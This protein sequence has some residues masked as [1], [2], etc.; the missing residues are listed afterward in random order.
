MPGFA[1]SPP[2]TGLR[3][4]D[5]VDLIGDVNGDGIDDLLLGSTRYEAGQQGNGA[6]FLVYGRSDG[7]GAELPLATLNGADGSVLTGA[8]RDGAGWEVAGLGDVNGDGHDDFAV[9]GLLGKTWV[10][11]GGTAPFAATASLNSL[12]LR[13]GFLAQGFLGVVSAAGDVNGDGLDDILLGSTNASPDYLT[14][15]ASVIFGRSQ[16]W[17]GTL[18]LSD[19]DGTLGFTITG[20]E[21]FQYFGSSVSSA[22]DVN[23]DGFADIIIGGNGTGGL[24]TGA[25][26]VVFGKAGGFATSSTT[27]ALDGLNGFRLASG[28]LN[29]AEVS[30]AGDVNGDGFGDLLVAVLDDA[31]YLVFGR[32]GGW[33]AEVDLRA[34]D[35][36]DGVRFTGFDSRSWGTEPVRAAGDVNGDGFAD[37]LLSRLDQVVGDGTGSGFVVLGHGGAWDASLDLS[38]LNGGNGFELLGPPGELTGLAVGSAGDLNDDGRPDIVLTSP[39]LA[40]GSG[41]A[42]VWLNPGTQGVFYRGTSLADELEGTAQGD[43]LSG[44]GRDDALDGRGGDDLL[45]G[46]LGNDTLRGGAGNDTL[47]AGGGFDV[48]DGGEGRD[49]ASFAAYAAAVS[50]DLRAP[51]GLINL[52]SQGLVSLLGIENLVGTGFND[53]LTGQAG[54]NRL[55]GGGGNDGLLGDGGDDVLFGGAGDDVISGG[56]GADDMAGGAGND[57]YFVDDQGDAVLEVAGEGFDRVFVTT[58][59]WAAAFGVERVELLATATLLLGSARGDALFGNQAGLA[60][61]L[62]GQ[63][64]DDML[65]GAAGNDTLE[66]GQGNDTLVGG[67]GADSLLGG[68]GLDTAS[69]GGAA[70][71]LVMRLDYA[72][73]NTGDAVGDLFTGIAAYQGSSFS[74]TLV[75]DDG[76]QA[77]R[78]GEGDDRLIGRRGADTLEGGLG[79]DFFAFRAEDFEAGVYDLITDFNSGGTRDWFLTTGVLRQNLQA[80]AWEGGVAVTLPGVGFGLAGGGVYLA[81]TTLE[82]FW[83]QLGTF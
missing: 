32:A 11:L 83:N 28:T 49:T 47:D 25:A 68:G 53:I 22:G 64:G 23:G 10:V 45:E 66:G 16:G 6:A 39:G 9:A 70:A 67:A 27:A 75:G 76:A 4:G 19:L 18:A 74:D 5:S 79:M 3:A 34:L 20:A 33:P 73:L 1:S 38:S 2:P 63:G 44:F 7:F 12:D 81:N 24:A 21:A 69:Y 13:G 42:Y 58:D 46:G 26:A 61:T 37:L 52:G 35:G 54:A 15:T 60:S 72:S 36:S 48:L 59:G 77:L 50:I 29:G 65:T 8:R 14:G 51:D 41:G 43:T 71:G 78:G 80:A 57:S 30:G 40:A 82:Q 31:A 17:G 55:E 56:L 62:R